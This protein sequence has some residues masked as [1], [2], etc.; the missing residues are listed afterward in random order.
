MKEV[1]PTGHYYGLRIKMGLAYDGMLHGEKHVL[2]TGILILT[3]GVILMK[4]NH[5]NKEEVWEVLLI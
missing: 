2:K 3:L 4:G 1:D 5:A